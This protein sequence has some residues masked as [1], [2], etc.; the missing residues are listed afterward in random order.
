MIYDQDQ[1][2]GALGFDVDEE[3][4]TAEIW[5][6]FIDAEGELWHRLAKELWVDGTMKLN[7]A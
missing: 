1:M 4:G 2:V 5:G 3:E 7:G 6:P